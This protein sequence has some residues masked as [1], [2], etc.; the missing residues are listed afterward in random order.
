VTS[1]IT[2][3]EQ[4]QQHRGC[5]FLV[6]AMFPEGFPFHQFNLPYNSKYTRPPFVPTRRVIFDRQGKISNL[7]Q[8]W[9]VTP[10][11]PLAY[12]VPPYFGIAYCVPPFF[13]LAYC[14]PFNKKKIIFGVSIYKKKIKLHYVAFTCTISLENISFDVFAC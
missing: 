13:G 8:L 5:C 6:Q 3:D 14:V 11:S 4:L 2:T 1:F 7:M 9:R 12:C 10:P